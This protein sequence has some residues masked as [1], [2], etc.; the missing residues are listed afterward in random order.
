MSISAIIL[1]CCGETILLPPGPLAIDCPQ[2]GESFTESEIEELA[3]AQAPMLRPLFEEPTAEIEREDPWSGPKGFMLGGW[4]LPTRNEMAMQYFDAA[5]LLVQAIKQNE[6]EDYRVPNPVLFLYRHAV[7]MALKGIMVSAPRTHDLS[8]LADDFEAFIKDK[9][10][11]SVP[12]WITA[13]LKEIA[14]VD[15]NS[16]AFRYGQYQCKGPNQAALADGEIYIDLFHL[17]R[18]MKTLLAALERVFVMASQHEFTETGN[19]GRN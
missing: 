4:S 15:P 7:E 19:S 1:T 6:V 5:N 16:T 3:C 10:G 12:T 2:C 17:Q 8:R 11:Q 13:R 14:G 18:S 9:C